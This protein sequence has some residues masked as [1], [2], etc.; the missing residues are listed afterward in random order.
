MIVARSLAVSPARATGSLLVV[1][2][3]MIILS[4]PSPSVHL[5][6]ISR[7]W[8]SVAAVASQPEAS[9]A[10]LRLGSGSMPS[11]RQPAAL[12]S[13]IDKR[14]TNPRPMT[15]TVSPSWTSARRNPCSATAPNVVNAPDSQSTLSGRPTTR[16]LGT[17]TISACTAYPAPAH[18]TRWPTRN[19]VTPCPTFEMDPAHEYPRAMGASSRWRTEANVDRIPSRWAF[20]RTCV[21]RSG[22]LRAFCSRLLPANPMAWRSVPADTRERSTRT[23]TCPSPTEGTGTS[24]SRTGPPFRSWVICFNL[25]P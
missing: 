3:A 15:A 2:A 20:R 23:S 19:P 5:A 1:S 14:P 10:A 17:L 25:P 13:W 6:T 8:A 11:T 24:S 4:A 9:A 12:A 18:A 21:T 16:L 7:N 22:R